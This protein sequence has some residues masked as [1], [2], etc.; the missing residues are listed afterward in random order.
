MASSELT[1][2]SAPWSDWLTDDKGRQGGATVRNQG[3]EAQGTE[4]SGARPAERSAARQAE[5]KGERRRPL[6]TRVGPLVR[7][8]PHGRD[9]SC[10]PTRCARDPRREQAL[11]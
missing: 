7:H 1:R 2:N 6:T 10:R 11:V 4:Q 8:V 9:G 3:R 5:R